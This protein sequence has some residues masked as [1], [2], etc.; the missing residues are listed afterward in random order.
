MIN[1][2]DLLTVRLG[3]RLLGQLLNNVFRYQV[4]NTTGSGITPSDAAEG[5][6]N[7]F[8]TL[9]RA[10]APSSDGRV[11]RRDVGKVIFSHRGKGNIW[12]SSIGAVGN[13]VFDG[14]YGTG[15]AVFLRCQRDVQRWHDIDASRLQTIPLH[16]R[17]GSQCR[18]GQHALFEQRQRTRFGACVAGF[19][20]H[21]FRGT[22]HCTCGGEV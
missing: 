8:K 18:N 12:Y 17:R 7:V 6:W 3:M 22:D 10:I 21:F 15:H 2:L 11:S 1:E 16:Y 13:A 4:V 14:T 20:H 9:Y 5:W 19:Y